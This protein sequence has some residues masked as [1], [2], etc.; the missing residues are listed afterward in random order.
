MRFALTEEQQMFQD[1]IQSSFENLNPQD[2]EASWQAAAQLGALDM[3]AQPMKSP[4]E[5][6]MDFAVFAQAAGRYLNDWPWLESALWVPTLVSITRGSDYAEWLTAWSTGK[7]LTTVAWEHQG[8]SD[9]FD[10]AK[11]AIDGSRI[12]LHGLKHRV[13]HM[14]KAGSALI[15]A[16]AQGEA[17]LL[18][19]PL[20]DS[21]GITISDESPVGGPGTA[22][23]HFDITTTSSVVLASGPE[24]E[25]LFALS[26]RYATLMRCFEMLGGAREV[27]DRT[28]S[29][30]TSR[31][32]FKTAIGS[33][34]AVKHQLAS[35]SI[36]VENLAAT[37]YFTLDAVIAGNS[38]VDTAIAATKVHANQTYL[39]ACKTGIQ[40]HGGFGY[41]WEAGLH[42]FLKHAR[43]RAEQF[44]STESR[45]REISRHLEDS[46]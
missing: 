15:T 43:M 19:L 6:L 13:P 26:L 1:A 45:L 10:G 11:A 3:F 30:V 29:H 8:S 34:Q 14:S 32:Q 9:P 41:T 18:L 21:E 17:I 42:R 40:L 16:R 37:A 33:F 27:L 28:V 25:T 31:Q 2:W 38:D 7:N 24:A 12:S 4:D 5:S 46:V 35:V 23:V 20:D 36:A 44:G 39:D 22:A